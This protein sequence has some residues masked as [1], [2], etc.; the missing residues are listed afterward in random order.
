MLRTWSLYGV[1]SVLSRS[2]AFLLLPVY[3]RVLSPEEYGI[4]AMI[5]LGLEIVGLLFA[6]G[7]KEAINR[8]YAGDAVPRPEAA[9]TGLLAHV[10]TI[11]AGAAL[12][13][14]A[15]PW[16]APL[17]L[18]D[19]ALAPFLRLG[20]VAFFFAHVLEAAFIYLRARRRALLVAG[21]S[22]A[23]LLAMVSLNLLFVV[24]LRWG[25]AGIFYAEII[26]MG[27]AGT[28]LTVVALRQIGT[29]FVPALAAR[30]VRFGTPLMF[31]PL[32]WLLVNRADIMFITHHGSLAAVGVYALAVQCAQAL[33]VTLV[34]PFRNFWDPMQFDVAR[35]PAGHRAYRRIFQ[36]F[37]FAAIVAGFGL[38]VAA[39]D[40]I[41]V[42]A[43]P[44]F[45]A[46]AAV[47][48]VLLVGY[49]LSGV[50]LFFNTALL[51]HKRSTLIAAMAIVTAVV[52][53]TVNALL[54]PHYLALGAAIA[55]VA[56]MT[57]MVVVTFLLAR[58][59]W[60]LRPDFGALAKIAG[61]ALALYAGSRWL[62]AWP[63]PVSL[64]VKAMLVVALAALGILV[65]AV[66]RRD[67]AA[68]WTAVRARIP[69]RRPAPAEIPAN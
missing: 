50:H 40:V 67:V 30:M 27:L 37:T 21:I 36:W 4:R 66:D 63:L 34:D 20:L 11:G 62:P 64:G 56:T 16:L 65:G 51:V 43:A 46:A 18:G 13:L 45:H 38:A 58:R 10:G 24:Y 15:A 25:V 59:L 60:R 55:R 44:A 17:L 69:W 41:G 23:N 48:P 54:V 19:A 61:L 42:M 8:F 53:I 52:N 33:M 32:A 12:G 26:V 35:D 5:A 68:G 57:T 1:S 31:L 6:F 2:I 9:S 3:T 7:L 14:L 28:V 39:D 29:A 49:V 22:V 47:V